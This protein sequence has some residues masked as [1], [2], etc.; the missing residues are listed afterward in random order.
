MKLEE[1]IINEDTVAIKNFKA[2]WI[3][4]EKT[5]LKIWKLINIWWINYTIN[6]ISYR[7]TWTLDIT[8]DENWTYYLE[9]PNQNNFEAY[10]F[11]EN[12]WNK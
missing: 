10:E 1:V 5:R 7:I 2:V 12:N 6:E 8:T 9:E 11:Y 4:S 3:I